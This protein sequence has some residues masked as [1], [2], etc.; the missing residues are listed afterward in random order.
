MCQSIWFGLQVVS[1][2]GHL[3]NSGVWLT[4]LPLRSSLAFYQ[5]LIGAC[6]YGRLWLSRSSTVVSFIF[7][8]GNSVSDLP[9]RT[10]LWSRPY[11]TLWN[12]YS[13][14]STCPFHKEIS[15]LLYFIEFQN[16]RIFPDWQ[17]TNF[18][19][20]FVVINPIC[21][22]CSIDFSHWFV[23]NSAIFLPRQAS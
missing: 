18:T 8:T 15:H 12:I 11:F 9:C 23:I 22:S 16:S 1:D 3:W 14:E 7:K 19:C 4:P 10:S 2:L 13:G 17:Q 6:K 20:S 5:V 21:C